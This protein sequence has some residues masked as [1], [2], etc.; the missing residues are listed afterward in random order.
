MTLLSNLASDVSADL[1]SILAQIAAARD[2]G[3]GLSGLEITDSI[4]ETV[5]WEPVPCFNSRKCADDVIE[6]PCHRSLKRVSN[7]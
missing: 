5:S 4:V 3:L 1:T 6:V 2:E 7:C